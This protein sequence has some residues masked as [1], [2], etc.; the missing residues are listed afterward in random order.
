MPSNEASRIFWN[1]LRFL[2]FLMFKLKPFNVPLRLLLTFAEVK[3]VGGITRHI[4]PT[5]NL[6]GV[7]GLMVPSSSLSLVDAKCR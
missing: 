2:Y 7:S 5:A 6:P 3:F 1:S 4:V